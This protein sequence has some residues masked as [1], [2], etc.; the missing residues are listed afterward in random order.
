MGVFDGCQVSLE[1]DSSVR[2][3]E[4]LKLKKKV[5]DNGGIISFIVTKK[6]FT[7]T[8]ACHEGPVLLLAGSTGRK[9]VLDV[10]ALYFSSLA[11]QTLA[12]GE[13]V[14][15]FTVGRLVLLSQLPQVY[16]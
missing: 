6:V 1:L 7:I 12:H 10:D 5:I 16:S 15:Y 11:G 8:C 3:K 2:F 14:W 4:K 9:L 13:R